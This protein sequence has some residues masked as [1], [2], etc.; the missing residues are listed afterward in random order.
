MAA[1]AEV[2]RSPTTRRTGGWGLAL[3]VLILVA[4]LALALAL[5]RSSGGSTRTTSRSVPAIT[6][7]EPPWAFHGAGDFH[8][9]AVKRGADVPFTPAHGLGD[10]HHGDVKIG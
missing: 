8:P 7:T 4:A 10:F 9:G 2:L 6:V 3:A 1:G 5:T